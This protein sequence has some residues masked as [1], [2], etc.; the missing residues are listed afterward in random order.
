MVIIC[1]IFDNWC[2][3]PVIHRGATSGIIHYGSK[4]ISNNNN[5]NGNIKGTIVVEVQ[6]T[7]TVILKTNINEH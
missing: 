4:E 5:N 1:G 3:E 6:I 7:A 2:Q